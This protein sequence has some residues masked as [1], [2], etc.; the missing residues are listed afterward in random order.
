[1]L[2]AFTNPRQLVIKNDFLGGFYSFLEDFWPSRILRFVTVTTDMDL[3]LPSMFWKGKCING[4]KVLDPATG[5]VVP[6]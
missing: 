3:C 2:A 6:F 4:F 1:M 5:E